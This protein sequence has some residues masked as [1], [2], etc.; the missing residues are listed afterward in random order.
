MWRD[1]VT[2]SG[3]VAVAVVLVM[4]SVGSMSS[5]PGSAGCQEDRI[6]ATWDQEFGY[7]ARIYKIEVIVSI[8]CIDECDCESINCALIP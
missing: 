4:S 7:F 3:W 2:D 6:V 5:G 1:P 8:I